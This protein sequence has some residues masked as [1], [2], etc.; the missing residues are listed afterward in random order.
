[1]LYPAPPGLAHF[2]PGYGGFRV[3]TDAMLTPGFTQGG[4]LLI[5]PAWLADAAV[6]AG[7]LFRHNMRTAR[8]TAFPGP[9]CATSVLTAAVIDTQP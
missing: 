7:L 5:A 2:L 3:L 8:R 6:A 1:M 4:A 9:S